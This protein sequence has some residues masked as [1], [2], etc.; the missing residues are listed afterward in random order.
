MS[1]PV[2]RRSGRNA[3]KKDQPASQPTVPGTK[4]RAATEMKKPAAK[5]AKNAAVKVVVAKTTETAAS[6]K[7]A[8]APVMAQR[9]VQTTAKAA[10][11]KPAAKPTGKVAK[12][13]KADDAAE[14]LKDGDFVPNDL[15]EVQTE[16]GSKATISG[17]LE[18]AQKGIIIFAYPRGTCSRAIPHCPTSFLCRLSAISST[19]HHILT[20]L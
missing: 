7:T 20:I 19:S 15:P 11:A 1:E 12:A 13:K 5:K 17:L 9:A 4:K 8:S 6:S 3:A 2:L 18:T 14:G 16:D 10:A